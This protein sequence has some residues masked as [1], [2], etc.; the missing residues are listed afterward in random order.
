MIRHD[1][2]V[3]ETSAL[4]GA[5]A[6]GVKEDDAESTMEFY[7]KKREESTC[8]DTHSTTNVHGGITLWFSNDDD[9]PSEDPPLEQNKI[10]PYGVPTVPAHV[11]TVSTTNNK[12]ISKIHE[13]QPVRRIEEELCEESSV[14]TYESASFSNEET[15]EV[16]EVTISLDSMN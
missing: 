4:R 16:G 14:Q 11:S 5:N 1:A 15:G 2:D 3:M 7:V 8:D 10:K 12:K 9:Q 13:K 6:T